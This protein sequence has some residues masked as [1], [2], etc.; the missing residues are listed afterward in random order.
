[1]TTTPNDNDSYILFE[2]AGATYALPSR[3][4]QQLEMVAA[5]ARAERSTVRRRRRVGARPGDPGGEPARPLWVSAREHDLR[6]RL[7]IV[8]GYG[9]TVGLIVDSAREFASI[10]PDAIK[11]LPEG[12]GG[13][14]GRYLRGIAQNG[15]RLLLILDVRELLDTGD[16]RNGYRSGAR[17]DLHVTR[18]D[19]RMAFW[20]RGDD[21]Q[22]NGANGA[23]AD[24]APAS[25]GAMRA[26]A[27]LLEANEA[28]RRLLDGALAGTTEMSQ[29]LRQTSE[30]AESIATSGEQLASSVE[31]AGG[32]D[33]ADDREHGELATSVAETA[34]SAEETSRSV[35]AV[36]ATANDMTTAATTVAASMTQMSASIRSVNGDTESLATAVA[37]IAA[38]DRESGRSIEAVRSNADDLAAAADR[39]RA[40]STA[41]GDDEQVSASAENMGGLADQVAASVEETARSVEG[42]AQNAESIARTAEAASASATELD[43]SIRGVA[44]L[45]T[46]ATIARARDARRGRRRQRGAAIDRGAR[47]GARRRWP[48]SATVVKE[49]VSAPTTSARSSTRST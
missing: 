4:I 31:R 15:E 35:T 46:R 11:P 26:A 32:V 28:Q 42:V 29:S 18:E 1:M 24:S 43:R 12:I 30:Q 27:A 21:R 48:K 41:R 22:T 45:A 23:R 38:V 20:T 36:T 9:R 6:S 25:N 37:Q 47:P 8:R 17:R 40:R 10:A 34:A 16:Q 14:S 19:R 5:H 33:R 13:T 49:S 7:V 3:Q 39:R 44:A 2:L